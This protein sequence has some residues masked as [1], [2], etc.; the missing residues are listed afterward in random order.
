MSVR[1]R[2][3]VA[4]VGALAA[5]TATSPGNAQVPSDPTGFASAAQVQ[6]QVADMARALKPGQT[7]LWRP[8]VHADAS[9]AALEY[10]T[11]PGL[12]AVHP[13]QTEYVVVIDGAGTLVS[14]GVLVDPKVVRADLTE[15]Q[16]I[17]G[18]TLRKLTRGDVFMI[19]AGV[20]HWFGID[21]AR[22]VLLGI[23]LTP[24]T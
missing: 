3:V 13:N 21:G 11:A 22:L 10:W 5:F 9:L 4:L 19:P 8:L 16:R 12:P 7:F 2:S 17:Q 1:N 24:H 23:K 18:G 15:G 14:G 6:A 20:P